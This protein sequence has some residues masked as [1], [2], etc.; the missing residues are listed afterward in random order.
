MISLSF[1][2]WE[3]NIPHPQPPGKWPCPS[4]ILLFT[5]KFLLN[6]FAFGVPKMFVLAGSLQQ[7]GP[8]RLL[9][10]RPWLASQV[11]KKEKE[12]HDS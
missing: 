5:L 1:L 7:A 9:M 6:L 3:A 8:A 12:N 2:V 11:K 4:G 10:L